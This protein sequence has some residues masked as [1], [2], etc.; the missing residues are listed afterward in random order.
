MHRDPEGAALEADG[1]HDLSLGSVYHGQRLA[2][3]TCNVAPAPVAGDGHPNGITGD[4]KL[5]SNRHALQIDDG[6]GVF[7]LVCDEGFLRGEGAACYGR[8][9]AD[10]ASDEEAG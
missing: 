8:R 5:C 10:D 1:L 7:V 3:R 4:R 9:G 2:F 6:D